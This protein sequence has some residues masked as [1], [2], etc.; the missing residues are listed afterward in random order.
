MQYAR[1]QS[2]LR[3]TS[4]SIILVL[5]AAIITIITMDDKINLYDLPLSIVLVLI[6]LYGCLF[7]WKL[8]ERGLL[9]RLRC[10]EYRKSMDEKQ[11]QFHIQEMRNAAKRKTKSKIFLE[12]SPYSK[13]GFGWLFGEEVRLHILWM[14]INFTIALFG[15]TLSIMGLISSYTVSFI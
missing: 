2:G 3:A 15:I 10:E 5:A 8:H 1:H 9:H 12:K 4:T 11:F 14:G 7:T 6:G 13:I